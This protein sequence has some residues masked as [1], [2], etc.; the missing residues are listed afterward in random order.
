MKPKV[1]IQLSLS[2]HVVHYD[3]LVEIGRHTLSLVMTGDNLVA[4]SRI[5]EVSDRDLSFLLTLSFRGLDVPMPSKMIEARL[6]NIEQMD[7]GCYKID[8]RY[9]S[10]H[11]VIERILEA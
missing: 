7:D 6:L 9:K 10:G 5:P 4:M 11:E 8:F 3:H 1:S 2:D